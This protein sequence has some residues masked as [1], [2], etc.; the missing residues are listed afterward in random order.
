MILNLS[1]QEDHI[2]LLINRC[3]DSTVIDAMACGRSVQQVVKPFVFIYLHL[4]SELCLRLGYTGL[5][6]L[7]F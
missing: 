2:D 1:I 7:V 3:K 4:L 5:A 6:V